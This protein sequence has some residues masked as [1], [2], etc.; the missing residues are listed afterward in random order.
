MISKITLQ[1]CLSRPAALLALVALLLAGC[2][3]PAETPT[4]VS[5]PTEPPL[6]LATALP[7]QPDLPSQAALPSPT[8]R[9]ATVAP[10]AAPSLTPSPAP[11]D[12]KSPA[13]IIAG[14]RAALE[15]KDLRFFEPLVSE[16]PMYVNYI[17]GGQPLERQK[18]IDDIKAR[19]AGGTLLCDGYSTYEKTLQIWTS[20]WSLDWQMDQL[21]YQ[22]CQPINPPYKSRTAAF[23]FAP[24]SNGNYTLGTVWLGKDDLWR[25]I[26]KVQMHSCSEA[27]QPVST[28]IVCSGAPDSR[29]SKGGFAYA[30]TLTSTSNNVRSAPGT[31]ANILG[32]LQPGKGV[33]IVDG[34]QCVEGYVWWRVKLLQSTLT[35]WTAEGKGS[36]YWLIPCSS[37]SACGQ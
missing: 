34:P 7:K 12:R 29:L 22:D 25:N 28:P 14:L 26:Y 37:A 31:G 13:S 10:T 27:Y 35:G 21:C 19:L 9:P 30:S 24:D 8:T 4:A 11:L 33:E 20:G 6:L 15:K 23:F 32:L 36:D 1:A 18:L 5:R 16:K 3:L 17:E 2:N